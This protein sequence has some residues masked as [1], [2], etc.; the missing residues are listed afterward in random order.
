MVKTKSLSAA[1]QAIAQS[2]KAMETLID[3]TPRHDDY[4]LGL[5]GPI[6]CELRA[7]MLVVK[8]MQEITE[9]ASR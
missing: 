3:Q 6:L 8:A 2:R 5:L 1:V 7:A 9:V 4:T